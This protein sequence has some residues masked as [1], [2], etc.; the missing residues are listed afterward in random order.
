[1][2]VLLQYTPKPS[3]WLFQNPGFGKMGTA[4]RAL[5]Y[6]R[7]SPEAQLRGLVQQGFTEVWG[8]RVSRASRGRAMSLSRKRFRV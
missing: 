2:T 7:D 1:M 8:L 3:P 5:D 4:A 6:L